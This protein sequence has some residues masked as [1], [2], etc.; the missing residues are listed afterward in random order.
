MIRIR[1]EP[2]SEEHL[3]IGYSP[4]LECALSLHVLVAPK[5]HALLHAWVRR[6]RTLAPDLKRRIAAFAF[7]FRWHVPDVLLPAGFGPGE[8]FDSEL[9]RLLTHPSEL[10]LEAFGRPLYDHGGRHGVRVYD[11]PTIREAM[12]QR[13]EVYG[14]PSRRLAE[15]LL[16]DPAKFTQQFVCLLE[17]YWES[18]FAVEW[19]W[20][21]PRLQESVI[22][23]ER[24]LATSGIWSVLGKLPRHCRV[25]PAKRELQIDLPHEHTVDVSMSNPLVLCPSCFVWPHLRVNCDRPWPTTLVYATPQQSREAQQRMPPEELLGALRALAD[26]T[27]LRVLKLISERPRTTQELAP[28]VGLSPAGLSKTLGRLNDAGLIVGR[29]EG[30]YVVYSLAPGRIDAVSTAIHDFLM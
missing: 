9:G 20:V 6:M 18:T 23:S 1:F 21:E 4:L 26:D 8:G 2:R 17:D 29:R 7:L 22:E 10:L 25:N 12:L 27:R 16:A 30:Y 5:Q 24:L 3:A 13:A 15:L 14:E 28:L 11:D 19:E